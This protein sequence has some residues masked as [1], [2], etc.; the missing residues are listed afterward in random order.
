[1][2]TVQR[3]ALDSALRTDW[4]AER[5]RPSRTSLQLWKGAGPS[6][7]CFIPTRPVLGTSRDTPRAEIVTADNESLRLQSAN[8]LASLFQVRSCAGVE[9]NLQCFLFQARG[10]L[11]KASSSVRCQFASKQSKEMNL[12]R[13]NHFSENLWTV[14]EKCLELLGGNLDLG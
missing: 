10:R 6:S 9:L 7:A 14:G 11:D 4:K 1:M 5:Y 13:Q 8:N 2:G 3:G 12:P